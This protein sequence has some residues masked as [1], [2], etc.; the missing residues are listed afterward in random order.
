MLPE[1]FDAPLSASHYHLY[2]H[3]VPG[4]RQSS[5]RW[6]SLD[7]LNFTSFP[8]R[9]SPACC[10]WLNS[11]ARPFCRNSTGLNFSK[12][13]LVPKIGTPFPFLDENS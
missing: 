11:R 10:G 9:A 3:G 5:M 2:H 13:V 4:N 12:K 6:I 8:A 7:A 1:R